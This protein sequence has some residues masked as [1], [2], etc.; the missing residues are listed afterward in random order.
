MYD[1]TLSGYYNIDIK[2]P[3]TQYGTTNETRNIDIGQHIAEYWPISLI[4]YTALC[5]IHSFLEISDIKMS[6]ANISR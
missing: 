5:D 3:Q 2:L 6:R 1:C 4:D